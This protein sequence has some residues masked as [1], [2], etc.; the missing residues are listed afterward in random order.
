MDLLSLPNDCLGEIISWITNFDDIDA[1]MKTNKRI[2]SLVPIYIKNIL[3]YY[4]RI[5]NIQRLASFVNAEIVKVPILMKQ[6]RD[7]FHLPSKIK[8]LVIVNNNPF[9]DL[10]YLQN[11]INL[12]PKGDI[13]ILRKDDDTLK[14]IISYNQDT[15]IHTINQISIICAQEICKAKKVITSTFPVYPDDNIEDLTI[16]VNDKNTNVLTPLTPFVMMKAF[17][18]IPLTSTPYSLENYNCIN[19]GRNFLDNLP[20]FQSKIQDLDIFL[21]LSGLIRIINEGN[22]PNLK[23]VSLF[24]FSEDSSEIYNYLNDNKDIVPPYIRI[25]THDTMIV[26][27]NWNIEGLTIIPSYL[28]SWENQLLKVT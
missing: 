18:T 9:D 23:R 7:I 13:K 5:A 6:S 12:Y 21:P 2:R 25:Y 24:G 19:F 8:S 14:L 3:S 1:L 16:I 20:Q 26:N 10:Y 15:L 22:F 27:R 11:F 28:P 17:R 4:Y